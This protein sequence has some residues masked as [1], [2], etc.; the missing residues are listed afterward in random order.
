MY[1][2]DGPPEL[3]ALGETEFVTGVAAM[4]ASGTFGPT[5]ACEVMF[6]NADLRLGEQVETVLQA[7]LV[8]SGG[9]FRG[10]RFST[11]FH[12]DPKLRSIAPQARLMSDPTWRAGF[13]CLGRLGLSFDAWVYHPQLPELAELAELA[14]AFPRQRSSSTMSARRFWAGHT[15]AGATRCSPNG[16]PASPRLPGTKTFT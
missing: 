12:D 10:I 14:G 16:R 15:P 13:A 1:R 7:H 5:R 8:A 2:Q 9:R 6:G 11:A 4:S 3:R